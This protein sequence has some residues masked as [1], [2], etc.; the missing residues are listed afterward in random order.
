MSDLDRHEPEIT[1]RDLRPRSARAG[2][3]AAT[4][5]LSTP[6]PARAWDWEADEP[7][8]TVRAELEDLRER[9]QHLE[10]EVERARDAESH[11]RA[12][13][14]RLARSGRRRRRKMFAELRD[15]GLIE[16]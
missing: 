11:V 1:A 12:V 3:R 2:G 8:P 16:G 9:V 4:A 5:V 6:A 15:C 10:D 13:L 7:T 14:A